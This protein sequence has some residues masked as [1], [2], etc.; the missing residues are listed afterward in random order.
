MRV[1]A[2]RTLV[3]F[4]KKHKDAEI[5]IENWYRITTT[6]EWQCVADIKNDFNSVDSVGNQHFVFNVKGNNYRLVVVIKFQIKMVYI[7]FIGTHKEYDAID[8][9]NI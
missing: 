9:P 3:N 5:A 1:I 8:C 2:H 6:A 4:Y 7:R